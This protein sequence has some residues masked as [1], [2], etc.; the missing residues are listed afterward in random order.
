M[1]NNINGECLN[2]DNAEISA[3]DSNLNK[4]GNTWIQNRYIGRYVVQE[5]GS[6]TP[7]QTI[8]TAGRYDTLTTTITSAS[9]SSSLSDIYIPGFIGYNTNKPYPVAIYYLSSINEG[10]GS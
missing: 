8:I 10:A 5:T 1:P 7:M 6:Y 3:I 9:Y 2:L 4:L